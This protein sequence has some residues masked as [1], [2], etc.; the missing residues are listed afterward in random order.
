MQTSY[1]TQRAAKQNFINNFLL[2]WHTLTSVAELSPYQP[3]SD[4]LCTT[5]PHPHFIISHAMNYLVFHS[6]LLLWKIGQNYQDNV[7]K[8]VFHWYFKEYRIGIL[9]RKKNA[10][11]GVFKAISWH[12]FERLLLQ[13][14]YKLW[15]V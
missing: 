2:F 9:L 5:K 12:F 11:T 4:P 10:I 15:I 1:P 8:R 13:Y 6:E 3:V 7:S 14:L